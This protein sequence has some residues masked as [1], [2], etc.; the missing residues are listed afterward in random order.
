VA[1]AVEVVMVVVVVVVQRCLNIPHVSTSWISFKY[2]IKDLY[3]FRALLAHLQ[4]VLHK[5]HLVYCLRM[6]VGCGTVAVSLQSYHS[7][8]TLYARNIPNAVC[9]APPEDEQ[10]MLKTCRGS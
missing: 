10:I 4:Y 6:S 2:T 8:L 9:L 3:M 5:R 7:Q 1:V